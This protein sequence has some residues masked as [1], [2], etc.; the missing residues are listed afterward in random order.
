VV[1]RTN[2]IDVLLNLIERALVEYERDRDVV[3]LSGYDGLPVD[4]DAL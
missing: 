3:K 4:R 2:H 1:N